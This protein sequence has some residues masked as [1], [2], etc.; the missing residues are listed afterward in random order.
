LP[1]RTAAVAAQNDPGEEARDVLLA[2][3]L[4]PPDDSYLYG[5][6]S[7]EGL[8]TSVQVHVRPAPYVQAD[9]RPARAMQA[10]A[11]TAA[12]ARGDIRPSAEARADAPAS[13]GLRARAAESAG[14]AGASANTTAV[15]EEQTPKVYFP[16]ATPKKATRFAALRFPGQADGNP[17]VYAGP[18]TFLT[19]FPAP[20]SLKGALL[21]VRV[22]GLLCSERNCRPVS[23]SLDLALSARDAASLPK[24][25]GSTLPADFAPGAGIS[26]LPPA[27]ATPEAVPLLSGAMP[28]ALPATPHSAFAG[29]IDPG[30]FGVSGTS[31]VSG[32]PD[33]GEI[34]RAA[35]DSAFAG[36]VDLNTFSAA[37]TP[38]TGASVNSA[39]AVT[40]GASG[41]SGTSGTPG[42]SDVSGASGAGEN[43]RA[44][45]DN[46]FASLRP[47]PF[48][49]E[50]EIA[51]LGEALFFGLLAGLILNL[52]PCV[53]PV[54]SLKFSALP[55]VSA[56]ADNRARRR[57]FR[58]HCLLFAA[59]ILTWFC[60]S[61]LLLGGA[62]R[63][64]GEVFQQ[65]V[66]PAVL[67]L[68]LFLLALSLFGVFY[69]PVFDFRL[70]RTGHPRRQAFV[71][72]LL[73]TLLATPCSGPLLGAVLAWAVDK[74]MFLLVPAV[75]SVGV[76]MALPY[77][78]MSL[79]PG[80]VRL[81]PK[82]GP[83]A[84]R[85]EQL[86][87]F[88]LMGSVVYI[89]TLLPEHWVG[90]FLYNLLAVAAAAW[91]WGSIGSLNAGRTRRIAAR[92]A[93]CALL[94]LSVTWGLHA[95]VPDRG[96]ENFD[97]E[98]FSAALGRE[99]MLLDFTADWCPS[100][101]A[102]E[103]A[104]LSPGR[105]EDL[106]KRYNVRTIKVD[107]T[108]DAEAGNALLRALRSSSIPLI[109]LFPAGEKAARP[110]V[111]RDLVTPG[112]LGEAA[113]AVFTN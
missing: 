100:C 25:E 1:G 75:F 62:G 48:R 87:G 97:P 27:G 105:M 32:T 44:A 77:L 46:V 20:E 50:V 83:W 68:V 52:M 51:S 112:Q 99:P 21:R 2:L 24:A 82:P 35:R 10:E 94:L 18:A 6:E 108:R 39:A 102:L 60:I 7:T 92:V 30:A 4:L 113:Q 84:L 19:R 104:T 98:R 23:L 41:T 85:L 72:G 90:P 95:A 12:D 3:T 54:I 13:S 103:Y 17:L 109:A 26:V 106:R 69:L 40:L 80:L 110:V 14:L 64:W 29:G 61:A 5:P 78:L 91:L 67:G 88:L 73:A 43:E 74:P 38:N 42:A 58:E 107:L 81:L 76:G 11:R 56:V 37:A 63:L 9:A 53:L 28:G 45:W 70:G 36:G 33:A 79:N 101:K 59:G 16:P 22:S 57:M 34:K 15:G 47:E 96:W 65:P 31:G 71:G 8:P 93:A 86:L 111:L 89:S 55:A 49:T 66:I